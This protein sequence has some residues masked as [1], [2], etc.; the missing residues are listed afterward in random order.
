MP[1]VRRIAAR[2]AGSPST[3]RVGFG[4]KSAPLFHPPLDAMPLSWCGLVLLHAWR[5]DVVPSFVLMDLQASKVVTY[6]YKL[7]DGE[8]VKVER[9]DFS[10]A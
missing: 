7:I 4:W 5:S 2:A 10:K 6:V 8:E 3:A 9:I 1:T